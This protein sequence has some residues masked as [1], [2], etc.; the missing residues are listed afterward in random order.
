LGE[1][2]KYIEKPTNLQY[3]L[4]DKFLLRS[5]AEFT[6][7]T[8]FIMNNGSNCRPKLVLETDINTDIKFAFSFSPGKDETIRLSPA[9]T[10]G[11]IYF[12]ESV[13]LDIQFKKAIELIRE[14]TTARKILLNYPP[15]IFNKMLPRNLNQL[16]NIGFSLRGVE[17]TSVVDSENRKLTK[18]RRAQISRGKKL[19]NLRISEKQRFTSEH[20]QLLTLV[21]AKHDKLPMHSCNDINTL[22]QKFPKHNK[23]LSC[24]FNDELCGFIYLFEFNHVRHTQYICFTEEARHLGIQDLILEGLIRE[25]MR[26]LKKF[27]F[28]ISTED[29]GRHVNEGLLKYKRS[30]G[31]YDAIKP[32]LEYALV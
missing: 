11:N 29:F 24:Y 4:F 13:N 27:S 10:F 19:D 16:I 22:C 26:D 15:L 18:G 8:D 23:V 9:T 5:G 17:I 20:H 21:L 25:S 6:E 32:V 12:S 28:G 3:Q 7:L 1:L 31:A 2:L 14:K 30:F